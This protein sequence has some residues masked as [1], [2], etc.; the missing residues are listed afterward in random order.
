MGRRPKIR[1]SFYNDVQ[2]LLR[3]EHALEIDSSLE[4]AWRDLAAEKCHDLATFLMA[5]P[6]RRE[7]KKK[8]TG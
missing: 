6:E 8:A 4:K 7:P 1:A 2:F 5:A 3:L